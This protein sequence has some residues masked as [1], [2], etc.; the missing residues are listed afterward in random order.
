MRP[1][2]AVPGGLALS[3]V[4]GQPNARPP[5]RGLFEPI[6][7]S[8][9]QAVPGALALSPVMGQPNARPPRWGLFMS[10]T[11]SNFDFEIFDFTSTFQGSGAG[12]GIPGAWQSAW[13]PLPD[14]RPS[15]YQGGARGCRLK[16]RHQYNQFMIFSA[17]SDEIQQL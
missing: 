9:P 11:L 12:Q 4:M 5:R 8:P 3:P 7:M 16:P 1:P 10:K 14:Q 15:G 17:H 6:Y 2:Q 13:R